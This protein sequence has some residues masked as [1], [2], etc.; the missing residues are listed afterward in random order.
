MGRWEQSGTQGGDE[1]G[2]SSSKRVIAVEVLQGSMGLRGTT[3]TELTVQGPD[4][5]ERGGWRVA[6]TARKT[7]KHKQQRQPGDSTT[8]L[9]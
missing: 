5:K 4:H 9:T 1:D 6:M 2:N 8:G 3:H 7:T